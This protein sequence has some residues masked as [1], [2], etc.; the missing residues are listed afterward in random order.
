MIS[1]K[2]TSRKEK[3]KLW[4]LKFRCRWFNKPSKCYVGPKK[5]RDNQA[6][7]VFYT[8]FPYEVDILDKEATEEVREPVYYKGVNI[9]QFDIKGD[10]DRTYVMKTEEFLEYWEI[11]SYVGYSNAFSRIDK[12]IKKN[13]SYYEGRAVGHL[14]YGIKTDFN[15][16]I[17]QWYKK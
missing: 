6:N 1:Y 16:K 15:G 11:L 14:Y 4:L 8:S 17:C 9:Y 3:F 12:L 7:C 13:L 10:K 5:V 2:N